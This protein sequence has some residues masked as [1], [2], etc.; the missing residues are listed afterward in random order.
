MYI[1]IPMV[2]DFFSV[3]GNRF[4]TSGYIYRFRSHTE[5]A[6]NFL[7]RCCGIAT[8]PIV[9]RSIFSTHMWTTRSY[10]TLCQSGRAAATASSSTAARPTLCSCGPGISSIAAAT[11]VGGARSRRGLTFDNESQFDSIKK[12]IKVILT[13]C[14]PMR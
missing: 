13:I 4:L 8:S 14:K 5:N 9:R 11:L 12:H 6:L 10:I 7:P 3:T 1:T 2:H